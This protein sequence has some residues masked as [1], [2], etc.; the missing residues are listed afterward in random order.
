MARKPKRNHTAY[1]TLPHQTIIA[2]LL[3]ETDDF[4]FLLVRRDN[5]C[6]RKGIDSRRRSRHAK[7]GRI[8]TDKKSLEPF[9]EEAHQLYLYYP[10][11]CPLGKFGRGCNQ[12]CTCENGACDPVSGVCSCIPGYHGSSCNLPCPLG[13]FG[14]DCQSKCLC[15]NGAACDHVSGACTCAVGWTGPFCNVTCSSG[16]YGRNCSERWV[17]LRRWLWGSSVHLIISCFHCQTSVGRS[18]LEPLDESA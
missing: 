1:V 9:I 4:N 13:A 6:G 7:F 12:T 17:W 10:S 14:K 2:E 15:M 18:A 8:L 11:G 16:F 5:F 3:H